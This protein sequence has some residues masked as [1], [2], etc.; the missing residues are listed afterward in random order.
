[1]Y[2]FKPKIV[3][4]KGKNVNKFLNYSIKKIQKLNIVAK[5]NNIDREIEETLRFC[6][7]NFI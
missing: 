5:E 2:G 7:N 6:K 1:M 4:G 3:T